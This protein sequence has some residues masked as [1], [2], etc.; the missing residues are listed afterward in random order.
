MTDYIAFTAH[1]NAHTKGKISFLNTRYQEE[2][3]EGAMA[4]NIE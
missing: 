2:I 4:A 1:R 3:N